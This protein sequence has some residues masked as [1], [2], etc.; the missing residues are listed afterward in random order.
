MHDKRPIKTTNEDSRM[1]EIIGELQTQL[2]L[3]FSD[4]FAAT[5][6]LRR[7]GISSADVVRRRD[8]PE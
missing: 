6:V 5:H 3:L 2:D 8:Q 4:D 7:A 1:A